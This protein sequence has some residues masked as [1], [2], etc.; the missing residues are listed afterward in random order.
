MNDH[1]KK[2]DLIVIGAGSAGSAVAKRAAK[3]G[4]RVALVERKRLGGTCLNAGCDPTK[5]LLYIAQRLHDIEHAE[6]YGIHVEKVSFDW[7]TIRRYVDD[8]ISDI[9]GGTHEEAVARQESRGIDVILGDARFTGAHEIEVGDQRLR[10][11]RFL[12][13]TGNTPNIPDLPG[14][15]RD[16][17]LTNWD[18]VRLEKLP[19][20]LAIL[21]GGAQGSEFGQLFQRLGVAVTI[22]EQAPCLLCK[23]D[24][25]LAQT[26]QQHLEEE[27][28]SIHTDAKVD[29]MEQ[30]DDGYRL[31]W[32]K[33]GEAQHCDADAVLLAAGRRPAVDSLNLEAARV[34]YDAKDGIKTDDTLVT[35]VP[36]IWAAGDVI[37][38]YAFTHTASAHGR[39]VS[40]NLFADEKQRYERE[41]VPWVTY[42]DPA[43]AHVGPTATELEEKGI[44]YEAVTL[45]MADVVRAKITGETVGKVKLLVGEEGKVLA[46]HILARHADDLIAPVIYAMTHGIR[47]D[48]IADTM[49]PYP[50]RSEAVRWAAAQY[51]G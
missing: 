13:A 8:L 44:A 36:H 41:W 25:E 4:H 3:E 51:G 9:R 15:E 29:A 43:L 45:D 38:R 31:T 20:R 11:E 23:D 2:Y 5:A 34:D 1:K 10:G 12:I 16:Q 42:T 39:V 6:N 28:I 30:R 17:V 7:P 32:T 24:Q 14:L 33:D 49:L 35:S 27:G 46:G 48:A 26:L 40:H 50:T 18:A 21:G 37:G 47:A 22:A 19:K